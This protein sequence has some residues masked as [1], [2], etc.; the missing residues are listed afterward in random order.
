MKNVS[1]QVKV[2]VAL[3]AMVTVIL[4]FVIA[5]SYWSQR[6]YSKEETQ[7]TA[8]MVSDAIYNGMMYPM[9][10]GNSQT[11]E[12]QLTD[13]N[14][15]MKGVDIFIFGF[16]KVATYAS[17]KGKAG[18]DLTKETRSPELLRSVDRLLKEGKSPGTACEESMDGKPYLTVLRPI[19]NEPRC[20]HCHGSSRSVLGGLMVRQNV[21]RIYGNVNALRNRNVLIGMIGCLILIGAVYYMVLK[22]VI[23]PIRQVMVGLGEGAEEV[24]SA[25]G[26]VASASQSL[27][28]GTSE[29]AAGIEETSSS[30]EEIASI[31]RRNAE[32]A[33]K[34]NGLVSEVGSLI[35]KG[36]ESMNRLGGAIEEI[37]RS[38]DATS[39]I[40][41]TIDEIAFQTNLLALNAAV[42]AARA[43][44]AGKG[45]AV[46]AEEVRHLAQRA[47]EAARNTTILIEGSVKNS[48]QGVLVASETAKALYEVKVSAQ[49]VRELVSE[50]AAASKEQALGIDQV[51]TAVAQINQVTQSNAAN[52]EESASASETLHGQVDQVNGMIEEL[53]AILG[54]SNGIQNRNFHVADRTTHKAEHLGLIAAELPGGRVGNETRASLPT[55]P[56]KQGNLTKGT[57]G[58]PVVPQNPKRENAIHEEKE[59]AEEVLRS[60]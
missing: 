8:S 50:I 9:S 30:L 28:E 21:E 56:L 34:A 43:G 40:V 11:I 57:E 29:Q 36:Q 12:E 19:L 44:D 47:G 55:L 14:K 49:K 58:M 23:R 60:F 26:Q 45:F 32:N 15:S 7:F 3:V 37:K 22:L 46:V 35:N 25:S 5:L 52:A 38:S 48:D 27:A 16:D 20:H 17:E 31:T 4:G 10:I 13:F 2:I 41:K 24:A 33:E 53:V 42:E 54:S 59:E 1:L 51:S 6:G 39:K 18:R